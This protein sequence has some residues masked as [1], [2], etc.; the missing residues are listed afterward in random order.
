[1]DG[2]IILIGSL[3]ALNAAIQLFI[4]FN[5][6]NGERTKS[7]SR[8][9]VTKQLIL[10]FVGVALIITRVIYMVTRGNW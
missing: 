9:M 7:H 8:I 6:K 5:V 1:M 2:L 4:E 3:L 10:L